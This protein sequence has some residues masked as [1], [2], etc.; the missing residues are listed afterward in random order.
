MQQASNRDSAQWQA[1]YSRHQ[2]R[3]GIYSRQPLEEIDEVA[4]PMDWTPTITTLL[5]GT[6]DD[7]SPLSLLR[8]KEED[9]LQRFLN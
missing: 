2:F 3:P 8:G 1:T 4:T 5:L 7:D 6:R 9:I